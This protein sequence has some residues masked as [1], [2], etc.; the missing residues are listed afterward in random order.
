MGDF[1]PGQRVA[2]VSPFREATQEDVQKAIT[3]GQPTVLDFYAEWCEICKALDRKTLGE[4]RVM[5][6]LSRFHAL[7]VDVE[8]ELELVKEYR[9]LGPPTIVF[10]G[11]DGG[12][13]EGLRFS[14]FKDADEF[15]SILSRVR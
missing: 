10:I 13:V 12:E 9:I 11:S 15:L 14:G 5:D 2:S 7:K 8:R 1:M 4:P 6:A 3:S